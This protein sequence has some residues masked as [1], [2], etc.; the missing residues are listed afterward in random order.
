[1]PQRKKV[2][3][4]YKYFT[5]AS[6][7]ASA[8]QS[9]APSPSSPHHCRIEGS[10][11]DASGRIDPEFCGVCLL[12]WQKR[13]DRSAGTGRRETVSGQ[14]GLQDG[15]AVC[16]QA[17]RACVL[18]AWFG[19]DGC[20]FASA[21]AMTAVLVVGNCGWGVVVEECGYLDSLGSW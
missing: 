4:S 6:A 21:I 1:M 17:R 9:V 18:Q 10:G 12:R 13:L 20:L 15:L 7:S 19:G 14:S 16:L 5:S 11:G 8:Q 3:A 2:T